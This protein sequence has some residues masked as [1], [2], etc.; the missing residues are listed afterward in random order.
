MD[1]IQFTAVQTNT[2]LPGEQRTFNLIP[3]ENSPDFDFIAFGQT[4]QMT[5][6]LRSPDGQTYT[7]ASDDPQV[8]YARLDDVG[9]HVYTINAPTPGVWTLLI[10]A[11]ENTPT[12]GAPVAV[13]G[14]LI[15]DVRLT[16]PV[17]VDIPSPGDTATV[18]AELQDGNTN[19]AGATV[20]AVLMSPDNSTRF[21]DLFDDGNHSDGAADDGIY[22]YQFMPE[23]EGIY[24]VT[25]SAS[26]RS[27]GTDFDRSTAGTVL[28]ENIV[29][30]YLPMVNN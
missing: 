7:P 24:S 28:V 1:A 25:V 19:I 4:E 12:E 17:Q 29:H 15:S 23:E 11:N 18:L 10:N 6:S 13:L 21:V 3:E 26:G 22:G 2:V 20:N 27:D 30:V 16:L 5:V 8:Q 14:S 9:I